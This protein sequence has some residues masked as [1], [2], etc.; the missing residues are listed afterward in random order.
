M[1]QTRLRLFQKV[2]E[3]ARH[4]RCPRSFLSS[5]LGEGEGINIPELGAFFLAIL[6][7]FRKY[8]DM[9]QLRIS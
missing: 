7:Y 1:T 3:R 6:L 8:S 2:G 4:F 5:R 9:G